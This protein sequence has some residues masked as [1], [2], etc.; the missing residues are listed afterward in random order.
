MLGITIMCFRL[1]SPKLACF[2]SSQDPAS[3]WTLTP[4]MEATVKPTENRA[5]NRS[6]QVSLQ[7]RVPLPNTWQ[8]NLNWA[9]PSTSHTSNK[10]MLN[11]CHSG[12]RG[13]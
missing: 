3:E 9:S 1:N 10:T 13:N 11:F 5:G 12:Y 8:R 2:P 4:L 7:G 6:I